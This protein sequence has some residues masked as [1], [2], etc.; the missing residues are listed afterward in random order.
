LVVWFLSTRS[1]SCSCTFGLKEKLRSNTN[2]KREKS[3]Q[4]T[5]YS[6]NRMN[7][8]IYRS[9]W[10]ATNY[11]KAIRNG[12]KVGIGGNP[13]ASY[14]ATVRTHVGTST[15]MMW[16]HDHAKMS[17]W[18]GQI[19][20]GGEGRSFSIMKSHS[21]AASQGHLETSFSNR[22]PWSS[23][24]E[25]LLP[26]PPSISVKLFASGGLYWS[27]CWLPQTLGL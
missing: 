8:Y 7:I 22:L 11:S 4:T 21:I 14:F 2:H 25:P 24:G 20:D 27:F 23:L 16:Q 6:N 10:H 5:R 17:Q 26:F 15:L 3:L 18:V 9:T 1:S 19:Q 12:R 13:Y